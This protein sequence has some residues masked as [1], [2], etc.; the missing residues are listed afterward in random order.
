MAGTTESAGWS[1]TGDTESMSGF[2][3]VSEVSLAPIEEEIMELEQHAARSEQVDPSDP[4]PRV[5]RFVVARIR[6]RLWEASA[7][8][9]EETPQQIADRFGVSPD[10]VIYWCKQQYVK[11]RQTGS[12]RYFVDVESAIE[13]NAGRKGA[14]NG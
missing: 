8:P 7:V 14:Y 5:I 1:N 3:D 6:Q 13:H 11:H 2:P 12:G 4:R 10:T 9:A